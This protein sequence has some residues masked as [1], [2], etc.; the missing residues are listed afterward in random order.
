MVCRFDG[1][2]ANYWKDAEKIAKRIDIRNVTSYYVNALEI[3]DAK[4]Y[5]SGRLIS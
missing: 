5:G 1:K 2:I 3:F 4:M